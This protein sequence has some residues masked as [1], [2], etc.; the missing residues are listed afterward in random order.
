MDLLTLVGQLAWTTQSHTEKAISRSRGRRGLPSD[1]D[2][3]AVWLTCVQPSPVQIRFQKEEERMK[4]RKSL[5]RGH[6]SGVSCVQLKLPSDREPESEAVR[7]LIGK[8]SELNC[9]KPI[10]NS[11]V[12]LHAGLNGR[13]RFSL[14]GRSW[15][16]TRYFLLVGVSTLQEGYPDIPGGVRI[17]PTLLWTWF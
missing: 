7:E 17:S 9:P 11:L 2:T 14:G 10:S 3:H 16:R 4:E 6:S 12:D 13:P 15:G 5:A 8:S 1:F